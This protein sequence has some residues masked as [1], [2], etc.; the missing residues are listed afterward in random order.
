MTRSANPALRVPRSNDPLWVRVSL[1]ALALVTLIVL[2]IIPVANVFYEATGRW[3][4]RVLAT[5]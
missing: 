5:T 4:R 1:T 3:R 2:V